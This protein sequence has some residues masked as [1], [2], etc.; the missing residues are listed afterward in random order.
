M[1]RYI[2]SH[3]PWINPKIS[4]NGS[5]KKN[6]HQKMAA[7]GYHKLAVH[8]PPPIPISLS[9]MIRAN[10]PVDCEGLCPEQWP[11]GVR[12]KPERYAEEA[13]RRRRILARAGSG[14]VTTPRVGGALPPNAIS[15]AP[16]I[17]KNPV[18]S[19]HMRAER[20]PASGASFFS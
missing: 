13:V 12:R 16:N 11:R 1:A 17:T 15:H 8:H 10:K 2:F 19:T 3:I 9:V 4:L 18:A 20:A 14:C 6:H 7:G 5:A